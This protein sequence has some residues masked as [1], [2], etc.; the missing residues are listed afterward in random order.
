M[1]LENQTILRWKWSTEII[2]PPLRTNVKI[3]PY[4]WKLEA[5]S[6][7][8]IAGHHA[9]EVSDYLLRGRCRLSWGPL[10]VSSLGLTKEVTSAAPVVFSYRHFIT[11]LALLWVLFNSFIY[12][13]PWFPNCTQY[14]RWSCIRSKTSKAMRDKSQDMVGYCDY[15]GTLLTHIQLAVNQNPQIFFHRAAL[16]SFVPQSVYMSRVASDA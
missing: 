14:S 4:V 3:E 7:G 5:I 15:Q 13:L 1:H 9:E 16:Q 11:S 2:L 8:L 12:F 10:S 6:S